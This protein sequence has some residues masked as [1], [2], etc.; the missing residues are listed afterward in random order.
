MKANAKSG[1]LTGLSERSSDIVLVVICAIILFL[2]AYPL[3]YV[4]IASVSNPYDVYAGKTFLLPSQFTLDGYKSVFADPSILTG[5]LNSFK[6]TI[7]GTVFSVVVLYLA[8]YP[9]SVKDLPGRKFIS[10]FFI[11]TMYFGGGMVPTYLVVKQTGLINNMWALFLPG[12]VA[13]GNMIIVRNFFEN[14]IPKAM[15]E[16][17]EIDGAS[18]WTTF[19]R[20]VVPL[21]RSIMAV[22]VVFSMVAYWND[23]FTAMIYLPSP[24]KAPLPLVLRNILIKS[25]AS[26]SQASTISG[27]FAE[28]NKMTE[29]IKF[30]SIIIA[31][32]PMLIIYP[33]VQKYFEKGFM[34][35][36][37]K[38]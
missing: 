21:S 34:A 35:G 38:G 8:A 6:Y 5:L 9:L 37:V 17:A 33:F 36:A 27:G 31:A 10:I 19:I 29:M 16:A 28:L 30:S 13:V 4:L 11:I 7:I 32:L 12:G 20:I 22:M 2:V 15:I 3:Y 26:A 14:S 25:S 24:S 18:K 1:K 23:W